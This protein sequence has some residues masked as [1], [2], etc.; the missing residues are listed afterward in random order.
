[1]NFAMT[2]EPKQVISTQIPAPLLLDAKQ[3][4][5]LLGIGKT[6]LYAL[7]SSGK[8]PLPVRLGRRT[9]WRAEELKSWI[10][11]GCPT[12]QKWISMQKGF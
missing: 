4:A 8:I 6:H 11:A 12:R 7:H 1:M 2:D 3:A 5:A 10:S 9:L